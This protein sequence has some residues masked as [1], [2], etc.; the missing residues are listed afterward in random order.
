MTISM[1]S[2]CNYD[3]PAGL[4][5]L[6]GDD[7]ADSRKFLRKVFRRQLEEAEAGKLRLTVAGLQNDASRDPGSNCNIQQFEDVNF[8]QRLPLPE[9]HERRIKGSLESA[10]LYA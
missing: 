2:L 10:M 3:E 4:G 5:H 7:I 8:D 9:R 1:T 6:N